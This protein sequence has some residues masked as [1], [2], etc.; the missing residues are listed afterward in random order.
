MYDCSWFCL[1]VFK[2]DEH[3]E[4]NE[5]KYKE[6]RKTILDESSGDEDDS[7]S[8]SSDND[9]DDDDKDDSDQEVNQAERKQKEDLIYLRRFNHEF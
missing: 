3:Y 5:E 9:E 1:D 7:S 4:E 8:G 6:I 2:Y